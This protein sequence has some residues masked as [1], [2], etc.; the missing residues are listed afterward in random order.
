M[1]LLA[2]VADRAHTWIFEHGN[3]N[4]PGD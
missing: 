3:E 4:N 2:K 1:P